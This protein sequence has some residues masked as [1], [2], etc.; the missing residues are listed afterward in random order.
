MAFDRGERGHRGDQFF[1]GGGPYRDRRDREDDREYRSG[2]YEDENP[3]YGRG[4][5]RR[6]WSGEDYDAEESIDRERDYDPYDRDAERSLGTAHRDRFLHRGEREGP[7]SRQAGT[8]PRGWRGPEDLRD[9][10]RWSGPYAGRGPKGYKRSDQQICEEACQ[11]LERDGEIDASD[12]E[13]SAQDG[14]IHLRGTVPDRRTK[15]RAEDCVESVYGARD[16][17]NEL[18]VQAQPGESWQGGEMRQ[19][20][21]SRQGAQAAQSGRMSQPGQT[22]T[23]TPASPASQGSQPTQKH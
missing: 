2:D 19:S 6:R 20:G 7:R 12:I 4:V 10:D 17:M 3:R 16:V 9:D 15:R 8:W 22:S 13:V 11:R 5:E 1:R 14:V 23:T 21:E 18:R